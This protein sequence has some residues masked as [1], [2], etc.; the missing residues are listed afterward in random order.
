M[1]YV[2]KQTLDPFSERFVK[3]RDSLIRKEFDTI[4][5]V[6]QYTLL[7]FDYFMRPF[8]NELA[9]YMPQFTNVKRIKKKLSN[10]F[11]EN[12]AYIP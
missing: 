2:V 4:G 5:D 3:F 9:T 8:N 7:Q 6:L 11:G 10:N 12:P 1:S